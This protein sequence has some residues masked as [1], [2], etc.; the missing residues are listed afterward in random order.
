VP[1]G[2]QPDAEH[3]CLAFFL[4]G[5]VRHEFKLKAVT[6]MVKHTAIAL[7]EISIIPIANHTGICQSKLD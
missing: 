1:V 6:L 4:L 5:H 7:C 2:V 3:H